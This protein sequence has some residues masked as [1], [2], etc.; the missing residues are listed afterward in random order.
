[1]KSLKSKIAVG[2]IA[3]GL[4]AGMGT[5]FAAKDAGGQLQNWYIAA[6]TITKGLIAGDVAGYVKNQSAQFKSDSAAIDSNAV[7]NV[8]V[9]GDTETSRVTGNIT[10][11]VDQ[12]AS[13][14]DSK[15][16]DIK[17]Y[18]PGEYDSAVAFSNGINNGI[19]KG[20]ADT[21]TA[22]IKK[23]VPAQGAASLNGLNTTVAT[24]QT[25]AVQDLNKKI[26]ETK[27]ELKDLLQKERE[28]AD[29]EIKANLDKQVIDKKAELQKLADDLEKQNKDAITN[30][31]KSLEDKALKD[32]D[33]IVN[34]ID[35]TRLW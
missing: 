18:M 32:L 3:T 8:K 21:G 35:G 4:V 14:L 1:M 26:E 22:N 19:V 5:A 27:G 24:A 28:T 12:Y 13:Q 2:V 9:T 15:S 30:Q 25:Q 29:T 7:T 17:S 6:S 20:I 31:G 33:N 10:K 11:S 16:K 23:D 34:D